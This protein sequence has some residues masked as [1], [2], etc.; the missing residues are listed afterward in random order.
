MTVRIEISAR[1][2]SL[3]D[4]E[5]LCWVARDKGFTDEAWVSVADHRVTVNTSH[6]K[7]EVS[8]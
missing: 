4:L 3:A 1:P 7:P 8:S 6:E 2:Q 5:H